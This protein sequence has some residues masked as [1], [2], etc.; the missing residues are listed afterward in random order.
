MDVYQVYDNLYHLLFT[1]GYTDIPKKLTEKEL[2]ENDKS[3]ALIET[4]E[5][6]V[7]FISKYTVNSIIK[8][9]DAF[10]KLI[11]GLIDKKKPII[12]I[13]KTKLQIN[14]HRKLK[15]LTDVFTVEIIMYPALIFNFDR[16]N[17]NSLTTR[18]KLSE[19]ERAKLKDMMD[20]DEQ[21]YCYICYDDMACIWYG[22][23]PGDVIMI[24]KESPL[25]N[26]FS[27]SY[28]Y[29]IGWENVTNNRVLITNKEM[30]RPSNIDEEQDDDDDE[31][32]NDIDDQDNDVDDQ[33][34]DVEEQD[35]QD[36][37]ED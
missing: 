14:L 5:V 21:E 1:R 35:E 37:D 2:I 20:I 28:R 31:Q 29:V 23:N 9:T 11:S 33:D 8:K 27:I 30:P 13:T 12:I 26:T 18:T 7:I 24:K 16:N 22:Y 34:N 25:T 4:K 36:D 32:D 6:N 17:V 10:S 3:Y 15:S 19:I